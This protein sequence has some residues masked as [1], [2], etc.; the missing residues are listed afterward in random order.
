MGTESD[1]LMNILGSTDHVEILFTEVVKGLA[2]FKWNKYAKKLHYLGAGIHFLY[3]VIFLIYINYVYV[4]GE[5]APKMFLLFGMFILH[6]YAF[7]YDM[8]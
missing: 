6:F 8:K 7:I 3:L 4:R 5:Y 2:D 1:E